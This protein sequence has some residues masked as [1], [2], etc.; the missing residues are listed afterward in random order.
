MSTTRITRGGKFYPDVCN[1]QPR[2]TSIAD[3]LKMHGGKRAPAPMYPWPKRFAV[4]SKVSVSTVRMVITAFEQSRQTGHSAMALTLPYVIAYCEENNIPYQLSHLVSEEGRSAGYTIQRIEKGFPF[5]VRKNSDATAE[6]R[7]GNPDQGYV[8]DTTEHS[9][10]Y[11]GSALPS[12]V[13]F[14]RVLRMHLCAD[15]KV[16]AEANEVLTPMYPV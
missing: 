12:A 3:I 14:D 1:V 16:R 5:L 9:G 11:T 15:C 10:R 2:S 4:P 7:F 8:C 13:C 6:P